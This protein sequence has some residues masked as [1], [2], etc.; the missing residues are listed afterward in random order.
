MPSMKQCVPFAMQIVAE[1]LT[2]CFSAAVK[3]YCP[4]VLAVLA[5]ASPSAPDLVKLSSFSNVLSS[6]PRK[7]LRPFCTIT[8]DLFIRNGDCK[9]AV[10]V[11]CLTME[12]TRTFDVRL[13]F[14]EPICSSIVTFD[15]ACK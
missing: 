13:M 5:T 9:F 14:V 2:F 6:R 4:F 12:V 1:Y 8:S 10:L 7:D 3:T 15:V 11:T